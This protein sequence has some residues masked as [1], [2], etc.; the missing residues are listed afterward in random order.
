MLETLNPVKFTYSE[1]IKIE[2]TLSYCQLL[3]DHSQTLPTSPNFFKS[4]SFSKSFFLLIIKNKL[5]HLLCPCAFF[6]VF[7]TAALS[8]IPG[9]ATV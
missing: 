1:N 7:K 9:L 5:K 3:I 6:K 2:L 4:P 8:L